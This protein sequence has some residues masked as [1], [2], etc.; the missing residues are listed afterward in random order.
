MLSR[1]TSLVVLSLLVQGIAAHAGHEHMEPPDPS[2]PIDGILTAHMVL[3]IFTWGLLLPAGMVLGLTK[4]RWHVP[5]QTLGILLTIVG[6][7]LAHHHG[8]RTFYH[9]AHGSLAYFLTFYLF[10]QVSFGIFLKLHIME[11]SKTR[12]IV[13]SLHSIFGKIFPVLS[14]TQMV[15]GVVTALG[16]CFNDPPPDDYMGQCLAHLIMGSSFQAYGV[17]LLLSLR[18]GGPWLAKR[19]VSQEYLDSWMILAWGVVTTF[20]MHNAFGNES[21][22]SHKDMQHTSLGIFWWIG[23]ATGVWLGR[24][25]RRNVV[26]AL[27][28]GGT[29]LAMGS[30]AQSDMLATMVHKIFV[31]T[32]AIFAV[33]RIIEISFLLKDEHERPKPSSFQY[34]SPLLLIFAGM[35]FSS[36]TQE[37]LRWI[38]ASGMDHVTYTLLIL[39][40]ALLVFLWANMLLSLYA[41]SGKNAPSSE[42]SSDSSILSLFKTP[43]SR[44]SSEEAAYGLLPSMEEVRP[45]E[46][47]S[48]TEQ[49]NVSIHPSSIGS[50][51]Q[52]SW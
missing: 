7:Q 2:E 44:S 29:G 37:Q 47:R 43:S 21:H 27:V 42:T 4:S 16:F 35:T 46:P 3:Q 14:W 18:F 15:L 5:V 34:L 36:A 45:S 32:L 49:R 33:V 8:G 6:V 25:A 12:R 48:S 30:H 13:L 41:N 39:S 17:A 1:Y 20:S 24:T 40:A 11:E 31:M 50:P 51:G 52:R 28:M 38:M 9:T 19:K 26:P 22:W 23:G 10:A